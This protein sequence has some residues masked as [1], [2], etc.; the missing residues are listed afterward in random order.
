MNNIVA[1]L[2]TLPWKDVGS[3]KC[4]N[5]PE[6]KLNA[7]KDECDTDEERLVAIVR[8]WLQNDPYASWRKLIRRLDNWDRSD[9]ADRIRKYAEK[10]TGQ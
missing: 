6:S 8:Y 1:V 2:N 4:L 9:I 7:I 10:L 3:K 5:V